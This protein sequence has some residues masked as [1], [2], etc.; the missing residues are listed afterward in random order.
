M[1]KKSK[2]VAA[3][4]GYLVGHGADK[5]A[6][7]AELDRMINL[8]LTRRSVHIE[9]RFGMVLV[10]APDAA[11]YSHTVFNPIELPH[12]KE[13]Y[14][15]CSH[16]HSATFEDVLDSARAHAAQ[17]SWSPAEDDDYDFVNLSGVVSKDGRD[18]LL[19]WIR[20]QRAYSD[21]IGRGLHPTAA[22]DVASGIVQEK[23]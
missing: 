6:A 1:A 7:Q 4:R 11:G 20:W 13:R 8:A 19:S 23:S 16:T 12:G 18:R 17:C 22:F 2:T 21:A 14:G 15:S 3:Q 9:N 10:V 5:K